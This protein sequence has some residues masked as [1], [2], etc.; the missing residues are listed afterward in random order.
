MWQRRHGRGA[1]ATCPGSSRTRPRPALSRETARRGRRTSARTACRWPAARSGMRC[2]LTSSARSPGSARRW[3]RR[4]AAGRGTPRWPGLAA[5]TGGPG[6]NPDLRRRGHR[7]G[8]G[9]ARR[10]HHEPG[11]LALLLRGRRRGAVRAA[12]GTE[13]HP[14]T[15]AIHPAGQ[16]HP[17]RVGL[18]DLCRRPR[19]PAEIA[20]H[21]RIR[22]ELDLQAE[23]AVGKRDQQEA[24]CPQD[25]LRHPATIAS[26]HRQRNPFCPMPLRPCHR[27]AAAVTPC[28]RHKPGRRTRTRPILAPRNVVS[29]A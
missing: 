29:L 20:E 22:I 23:M 16:G 19:P 9:R 18:G 12:T 8:P 25:R 7:A 4:A 13:R 10:E 2:S 14:E 11:E 24:S 26:R 27:T 21:F 6:G 17:P 15:Q 5:S 3:R 1:P 28:H